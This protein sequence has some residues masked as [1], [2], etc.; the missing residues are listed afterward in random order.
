MSL[1]A[2][3]NS[4]SSAS[5]TRPST[6]TTRSNSQ[7]SAASNAAEAA[8]IRAEIRAKQNSIRLCERALTNLESGDAEIPQI[9]RLVA[10]LQENFQR[11]LRASH[12]RQIVQ[13]IGTLAEPSLSA[14]REL[15]SARNHITNEVRV[16]EREIAALERAL[17]ALNRAQTLLRNAVGS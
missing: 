14:D 8:N 6:T 10:S 1:N 17:E 12:T 7:E 16:L 3:S 15:R 13:S 5:T 11:Y 2:R 9:N 4:A